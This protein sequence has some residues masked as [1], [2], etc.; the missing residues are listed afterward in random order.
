[1]TATPLPDIVL[2]SRP[3][4]HLCDEARTMLE[5][6]LAVRAAG[7]LPS[8]TTLVERNIDADPAL[9]RAFFE[10]IPVVEVGTRRLELVTSP[11]VLRRFL[12]E[13][14]DGSATPGATDPS[15]R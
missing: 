15:S 10:T 11:S 13:A 12:V 2:Y 9:H 7:G 14:L 5:G 4:C 3:G 8:P 1:M 6:L